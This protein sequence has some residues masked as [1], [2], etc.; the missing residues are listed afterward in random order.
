MLFDTFS[1]HLWGG[2]KRLFFYL[3]PNLSSI[4]PNPYL[5]RERATC[6]GE[7]R[8][9]IPPTAKEAVDLLMKRGF[10]ER[11]KCWGMGYYYNDAEPH[12]G[13]D[14]FASYSQALYLQGNETALKKA[15]E[16]R[17]GMHYWARGF[18]A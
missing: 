11:E 7:N 15:E 4:P 18:E 14:A 9:R 13:A 3:L 1:I 16:Q 17:S 6:N 10:L 2:S 5:K 12:E 8:D